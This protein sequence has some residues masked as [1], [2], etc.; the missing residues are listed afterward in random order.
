MRLR[1]VPL[2]LTWG[3]HDLGFRPSM[4]DRFREDFRNVTVRRLDAK[5]YIQEDA[6]AEI[7]EAIAQFLKAVDGTGASS[8]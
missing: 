6:P 3:I 5:H 4:M 7:S 2:L 8:G 1:D